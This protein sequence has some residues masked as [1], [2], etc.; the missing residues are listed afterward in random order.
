[1]IVR[2]YGMWLIARASRVCEVNIRKTQS[3]CS[4]RAHARIVRTRTLTGKHM[5]ART[6]E[7]TRAVNRLRM[8]KCTR[9]L[10]TYP[11]PH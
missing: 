4:A 10:Q 8:C 5:H 11:I 3:T 7:H 2:V 6:Q 1:M 9:S